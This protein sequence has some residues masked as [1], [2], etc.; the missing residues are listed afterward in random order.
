MKLLD[1]L[2]YVVKVR[3]QQFTLLLNAVSD[4]HQLLG[5]SLVFQAFL[6]EQPLVLSQFNFL[7]LGLGLLGALTRIT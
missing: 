7:S 1:V 6:Q 2:V 4:F 3:D 5:L